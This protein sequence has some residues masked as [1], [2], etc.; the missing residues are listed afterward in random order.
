[1]KNTVDFVNRAGAV[2]SVIGISYPVDLQ[3]GSADV[4]K[5]N[6]MNEIL[7]GGSTGRLFLNLRERHGW[8]YGSYSSVSSDDII[9]SVE[10]YAK[11]RNIVTDSSITEMLKE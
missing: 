11:C 8:T 6:A 7:G 3:I 5:A 10:V 1:T 2:Q 4:I 9:G